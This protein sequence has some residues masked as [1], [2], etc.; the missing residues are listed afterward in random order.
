MQKDIDNTQKEKLSLNKKRKRNIS[1]EDLEDY[2]DEIKEKEKN[3][4]KKEEAKNYLKYENKQYK[5]IYNKF[6]DVNQY[7]IGR[8]IFTTTSK[9]TFNYVC[10]EIKSDSKFLVNNAKI[11]CLDDNTLLFLLSNNFLHIFEIKEDF[12]YQLIK[13]ISLNKDNNFTFSN[14]PQKLFF[15]NPQERKPRKKNEIIENNIIIK[16]QNV[17]RKVNSILYLIILSNAERYLCKFDLEKYIFKSVKNFVQKNAPKKFFNN[18]LKF[19][20][21]NNNKILSYNQNIV[22]VQKIFGSHKYKDFKINNIESTSLLNQNMFSICTPDIVYIYDTNNENLIGDFRTHGTDKK[23]KLLRPENNLLMIKS[24]WDVALYDLESLMIFQKLKV[25]DIN[26]QDEPIKK[27]KQLTNNN[28]A[29]LFDTCFVMYNLEKN[30]ITYKFNYYNNSDLNS[31]DINNKSV[32]TEINPNFIL[33]NDGEKNFY[34]LNSIKADKIAS[35]NINNDNFSLCEKIKKYNFKSDLPLHKSIEENK[36]DNNYIL[37]KNQQ[38]SF[39][40]SSIK[41]K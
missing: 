22:Y 13:E 7:L 21:F 5:D 12:K 34:I 18:D 2:E 20:I 10:Q 30:S 9:D 25:N 17:K 35:L 14:N 16:N 1:K 11:L 26:N 3:K 37:L 40:L 29:I 23:A 41:E 19:K 27:I 24:K 36:S 33:V 6:Y 31:I 8:N 28:I 4:I 39:I 15:I 38:N 32:L